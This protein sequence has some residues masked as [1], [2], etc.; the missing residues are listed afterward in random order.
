MNVPFP[1]YNQP[2]VHMDK[3]TLEPIPLT[4]VPTVVPTDFTSDEINFI[5]YATEEPDIK[6]EW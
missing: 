5:L 4:F 3:Q 6:I 2:S 1:Q